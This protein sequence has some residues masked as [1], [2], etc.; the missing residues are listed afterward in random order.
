MALSSMTGFARAEGV[1]GLTTWSWEIK[2][3]NSKGLD[4]KLR[5]P[6]GLDAVEPTIRQ[7][8]SAL[9]AR[10][11]LFAKLTVKREGTTTEVR[12]NEQVLARRSYPP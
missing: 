12:I 11:S 9:V 3:V 10:G 1:S 4:V 6:P 8:I 2:S 7:K 5:L